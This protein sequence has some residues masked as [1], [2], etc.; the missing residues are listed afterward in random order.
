MQ[1]VFNGTLRES[2]TYDAQ[3]KGN[4]GEHAAACADPTTVAMT[5]KRAR[6]AG[7]ATF[8]IAIAD[9]DNARS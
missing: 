9:E 6:A 2:I 7:A 3:L 4:W 1:H 8:T 5:T